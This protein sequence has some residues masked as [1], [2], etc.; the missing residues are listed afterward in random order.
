MILLIL[1]CYWNNKENNSDH[2]DQANKP[3]LHDTHTRKST[4][5]VAWNAIV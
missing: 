3:I 4:V 5:R 2:S 1:K